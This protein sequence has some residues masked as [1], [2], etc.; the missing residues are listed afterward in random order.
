MGC[1]CRYERMLRVVRDSHAVDV[2]NLVSK[3]KGLLQVSEISNIC[4]LIVTFFSSILDV[5]QAN[6]SV[7]QLRQIYPM[8]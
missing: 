6:F 4:L 3:F 1:F 5:P 7:R 8:R 2:R